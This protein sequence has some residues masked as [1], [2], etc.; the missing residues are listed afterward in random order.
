MFYYY[1]PNY[2]VPYRQIG[3]ITGVDPQDMKLEQVEPPFHQLLLNN[4]QSKSV[5]L[6]KVAEYMILTH[7][8]T[9]GVVEEE[10]LQKPKMVEEQVQVKMTMNHQEK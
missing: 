3:T 8:K 1:L 4:L 10:F 5:N 6:S 9:L 2:Y 7:N